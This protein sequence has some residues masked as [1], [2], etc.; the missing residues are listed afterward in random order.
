[1]E[2]YEKVKPILI[3]F[4]RF[5]AYGFFMAIQQENPLRASDVRQHNE[6]MVLSMIY[7]ARV[8]GISQSEIVMATGLKAPTVF[9]IF[10]NLEQDGLIEPLD[11]TADKATSQRKGRRPVAYKVK[12][13]A[14]YTFGIEFWVDCIALGVFDFSGVLVCDHMVSLS[15]ELGAHEVTARIVGLVRETLDSQCLD[16]AKVLGIGVAAPGQVNV[17]RREIVYY[18]RF[19]DMR[20]FPIA[21]IMEEALDIPVFL[22]NNCSAI[23]LSEYRY[24]GYRHGESLFTFLIRSGVNGAFV[25]QGTIYTTSQ[26]TTLEAGHLPISIDGPRCVCGQTGCLQAYITQLNDHLSNCSGVLLTCLED[27]LKRDEPEALAAIDEIAR[28]LFAAVKTIIRCFRPKAFLFVTST[29]E[30]GLRIAKA[31]GRLREEQPGGFDFGMIDFI[32]HQYH[33]LTALHGASDLVIN[34]YFS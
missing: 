27:P 23:A 2:K 19:R 18:P 11:Q 34:A 8:A 24:G 16:S 33:P 14:L 28:Y 25:N 6:K 26:S 12:R 3:D 5:I 13:N 21:D 10:N 29:E 9:R 31:V 22:H 1:M 17:A 7:Q 20:N 32:A 30:V 4:F 15:E